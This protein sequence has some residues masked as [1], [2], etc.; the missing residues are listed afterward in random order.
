MWE[1]RYVNGNKV[2]MNWPVLLVAKYQFEVFLFIKGSSRIA[3]LQIIV[4]E[5]LRLCPY[6]KFYTEMSDN[7]VLM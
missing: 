7:G 2:P 1:G 6:S 3:M 5:H 4:P